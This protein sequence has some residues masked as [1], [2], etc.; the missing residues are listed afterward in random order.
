MNIT[1]KMLRG[2]AVTALVKRGYD[3][4]SF[5]GRG[6]P[7]GTFLK[8]T[9]G[10]KT[11]V[12]TVRST[13]DRWFAFHRRDDGGWDTLDKAD[14]VAVASVNDRKTPTKMEVY[15]LEREP[16]MTA[17][18]EAFEARTSAGHIIKEN[19]PWVGLDA[20]KNQTV[21]SVGSGLADKA[22]WMEVID[23]MSEVVHK[24]MTSEADAPKLEK[25]PVALTIVEAKKALAIT[26]G[27]PTE[28]IEITIRG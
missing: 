16:V 11:F 7:A 23:P 8:L 21:T 10:G 4:Q 18:N 22:L 19:T 5:T 15:L 25:Q 1:T 3:V 6:R 14:F 27:V 2:A 28:A 24:E 17:F 13:R 20:P 9:K 12:C 26:Y